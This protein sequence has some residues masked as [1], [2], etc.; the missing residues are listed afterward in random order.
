VLSSIGSYPDGGCFRLRKVLAERVGVTPEELVFGAGSNEL[1]HLV[2][3]A[4]CR[5]RLDEVLTHQYAFISYRL[6]A[7]S[8]DV[9][10]VEAPVTSDLRCDVDALIACMSKRTR[11]I[12][13]AHPNNP[14]GA[15]LTRA[16]LE[17]VIE[18]APRGALLVVDEAYHEFASAADAEYPSSQ[19][20]R[21]QER[22]LILT[23]RTFS[24]AHGLAGLRVGYGIGDAEVIQY[25]DRIRRPFNVNAVA[26][27]AAIAALDDTEHVRRSIEVAT[28]GVRELR[29]GITELGLDTYPSLGNF[30]LVEVGEK[31]VATYEQL[32]R[33]GIIVRPLGAWG[34]PRHLRISAGTGEQNQRVLAALRQLLG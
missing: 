15:H 7:S 11:V 29:R 14:T 6:A 9:P 8:R 34:L 33:L 26:Q 13:L 17:R 12:F 28:A 1:I 5:P 23:L 2:V 16:E 31:A 19:D 32:L 24:K 3:S 30:V 4:F 20:Y 10:L 18:S 27:A 25:L 21:S 22:R